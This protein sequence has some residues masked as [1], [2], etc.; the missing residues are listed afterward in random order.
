MSQN[1]YGEEIAR[2]QVAQE[3][4]K[5]GLDQSRHIREAV[6]KDLEV[7]MYLLHTERFF[8][9]FIYLNSYNSFSPYNQP[10]NQIITELKKIMTLFIF[11]WF[12]LLLR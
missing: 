6:A 12:H 2:L 11:K 8:C 7:F 5:K 10:Y 1:K 3:Y 4:I 9:Y